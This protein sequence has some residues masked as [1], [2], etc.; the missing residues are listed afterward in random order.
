VYTLLAQD[1]TG[2]IGLNLLLLSMKELT[3][4]LYDGSTVTYL[5]LTMLITAQRTLKNPVI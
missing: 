1:K 4:K 5:S 2:K 3:W